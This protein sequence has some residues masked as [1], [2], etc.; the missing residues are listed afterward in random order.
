MG[1]YEVFASCWTGMIA[2]MTDTKYGK[3][4]AF[5]EFII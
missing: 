1:I 3:D 4:M 2:D 5:K